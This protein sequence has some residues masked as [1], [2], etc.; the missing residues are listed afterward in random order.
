MWVEGGRLGTWLPNTTNFPLLNPDFFLA[1]TNGRFRAFFGVISRKKIS[2][3]SHDRHNRTGTV[4]IK[5]APVRVMRGKGEPRCTAQRSAAYHMMPLV[6]SVCQAPSFQFGPWDI[7]FILYM[8][9]CT[10]QNNAHRPRLCKLL[11]LEL[12]RSPNGHFKPLRIQVVASL[13]KPPR[14][15][16][17]RNGRCVGVPVGR[18]AV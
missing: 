6:M 13:L 2:R 15:F 12:S 1:S 16:Q 8:T 17:K 5:K 10:F 11:Y 7:I 14:R 4:G 18:Q 9:Q 3:P